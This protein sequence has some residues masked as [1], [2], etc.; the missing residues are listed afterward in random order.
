MY[1]SLLQNKN[2]STKEG[3]NTIFSLSY[4]CYCKYYYTNVKCILNKTLEVDTTILFENN[5]TLNLDT[6]IGVAFS[7]KKLVMKQ[8]KNYDRCKYYFD[9]LDFFDPF[10]YVRLIMPTG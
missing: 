10:E 9:S 7:L 4:V 6:R 3:S 5:C 2:I 8:S 1:Q